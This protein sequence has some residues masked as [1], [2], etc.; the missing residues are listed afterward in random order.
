MYVQTIMGL[1][2]IFTLG[3][4]EFDAG[5]VHR[6]YATICVSHNNDKF[7]TLCVCACGWTAAAAAAATS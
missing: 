7:D 2:L 5:G 3:I 6:I 4:I 1:G